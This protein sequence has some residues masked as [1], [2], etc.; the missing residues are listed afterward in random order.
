[1]NNLKRLD[2]DYNTVVSKPKVRGVKRFQ[3][4]VRGSSLNVEQFNVTIMVFAHHCQSVTSMIDINRAAHFRR[5]LWTFAIP[6][7]R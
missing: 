7:N 3:H 6:T 2:P 1:M 4:K 5:V